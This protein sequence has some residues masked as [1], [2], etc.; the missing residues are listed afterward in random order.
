MKAELNQ[1][2]TQFWGERTPREKNLL[3]WGGAVLAVA[4]A[5]SVLWSP[6]QEGRARI[7]RALPAMRAELA[8]MTAQANEARSLTA[9]AQG[10]APTGAA[11]KDALTASLSDHGMPGGQIQ[12]VGNGVQIQLKNA[13]FPAWTQW[14]DDVR[15]QYKVQVGEAH[16][17]ALKD[18]G[19]VDLTAVMQPS[20][21]K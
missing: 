19:Q 15:K 1:T 21:Q 13:S 14:L 2:L 16:V 5:Y 17:T 11:L 12:L 4:I 3:G 7:A 10:V 20:T 9:A 6:A 18:D 8:K